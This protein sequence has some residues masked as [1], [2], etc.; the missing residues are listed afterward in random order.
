MRTPC[1]IVCFP[2]N[3]LYWSVFS[4]ANFECAHNGITATTTT[5]PTSH[6]FSRLIIFYP[7]LNAPRCLHSMM[8][9]MYNVDYVYKWNNNMQTF[10]YAVHMHLLLDFV[11]PW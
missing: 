11:T 2:S 9:M 4:A 6:K 3:N 1:F 5:K 8:M 10:F 7:I